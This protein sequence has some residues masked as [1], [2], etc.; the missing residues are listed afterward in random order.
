MKVAN[1]II[2]LEFIFFWFY[3]TN[4]KNVDRTSHLP[5][6]LTKPMHAHEAL[7]KL[8]IRGAL[9]DY[10]LKLYMR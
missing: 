10:P 9:S 7:L 8:T 4:H 5:Q 2:F 6:S 3:L 1:W